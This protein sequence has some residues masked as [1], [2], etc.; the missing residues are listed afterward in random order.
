MCFGYFDPLRISQ[1]KTI[2]KNI[3][4]LSNKPFPGMLRGFPINHAEGPVNNLYYI[5]LKVI[6]LS[7]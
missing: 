4:Y 3:M 6:K 7:L 2:H 1:E 5:Y